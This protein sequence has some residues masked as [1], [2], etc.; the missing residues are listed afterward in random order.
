MRT[1]WPLP[2]S[3]TIK[4]TTDGPEREKAYEVEIPY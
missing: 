3:P 1:P 4:Y 2:L